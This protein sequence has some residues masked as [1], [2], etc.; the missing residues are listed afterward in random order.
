MGRHYLSPLFQPAAVAVYGASDREGSPGREVFA[1]LRASGF[2]GRLFPVNPRRETVAGVPALD[3]AAEAG[4]PIDLAVVAAP[5]EALPDIV[6]DGA[7][8][9]I[10]FALI[11]SFVYR[12][13]GDPAT[14]AVERA[15]AAA[16]AHGIR[17]LGPRCLGI[18]RP[19]LGLN[20]SLV[21]I[22]AAS[23]RLALVSQ[24][25]ALTTAIL[26]WA[27][28]NE[29]GFS[30]VISSGA[31][32]DI[33]LGEVLDFLASDGAT[34]GILLYVEAVR[35]ARRFMSA[36][37][38]AA[39]VK[40]VVVLK[41]GRSREVPGP[42]PAGGPPVR[43]DDVFGVAL[44]R[45]GAVR[46]R[47]IPQLFAAALTLTGRRRPRGERL[48]IVTNGRGPGL[49]AADALRDRGYPL[50]DWSPAT[51]EA[52]AAR[53]PP[54]AAIANPLDVLGDADPERQAAA[55]ETALADRGTDAVLALLT[56][57]YPSDPEATAQRMVGLAAASRKP[58]LAC[59]MGGPRVTAAREI[60]RHAGLPSFK[61]P[62]AAVEGFTYLAAHHR[63]RQALL[64]APEPLSEGRPPDVER[65]AGMLRAAIEA[66]RSAL[67]VIE[68]KALLETFHIPVSESV[69]VD[70][71]E[72]ARAAAERQGYPVAV[73]ISS[74]DIAGKTAIGGVQLNVTDAAALERAYHEVRRAAAANAPEAR[75]DGVIVEAMWSRRHGRELQVA[76]V[77]DPVFGPVIAFGLGGLAADAFGDRALSLPPLNAFLARR[78]I[79]GTRV[80]RTLAAFQNLPPADHGAL[81]AILLRV[82]EMVCELPW[83]GSLVINPLML[84]ESGA[85]AVD[86]RVTLVAEPPR[87]A[88]YGHMVIHPYPARL[89]DQWTARDG[90]P[91][92]IR[93]LRPEDARMEQAF[94]QRLSERSRL[95]RFMSVV[96]ELSPEMMSRLTQIDYDREMAL[97][98][99]TADGTEV[100]V[101]RYAANPD[102]TSCEFAVVVADDWQG[103]GLG[104]EMMRRIIDLAAARGFTRMEGITLREN[105]AMQVLARHLGFDVHPDPEDANLYQ[106]EKRLG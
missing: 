81:E 69:R 37:R 105:V 49:M 67:G 77:P 6:A 106:L 21:S 43:A 103:R 4:M 56:P 64:Q 23:G 39:R 3:S 60:L 51:R 9:G 82:S 100:A 35:D 72:A 38:A 104:G 94:V 27:A 87:P 84:D 57:Q 12:R 91:L 52:L 13:P 47:S 11:L 5:P 1:N 30:T 88:R 79:E 99:L 18:Q 53:L 28:D 74:P 24:S 46:V 59:W 31:D 54:D 70:S 44:A 7:A 78:L 61:T 29:A 102:E 93:P 83:M 25:R 71:P 8:A 14:D 90:T 66:G 33:G 95:M 15:L 16:R 22:A 65:A 41:S 63:N 17:F 96:R 98:A 101:A 10:R 20:A 34:D 85:S 73:K 45:G 19:P 55:V 50:P 32:D 26:D 80:A 97:V 48:G 86:A 40:P 62:E 75:V 68:S 92:H 58:L 76:V 42:S 2:R 36:L 89:A